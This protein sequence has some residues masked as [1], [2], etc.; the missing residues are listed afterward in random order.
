M[1][2]LPCRALPPTPPLQLPRIA[3]SPA[4]PLSGQYVSRK[5]MAEQHATWSDF[6]QPGSRFYCS[7]HLDRYTCRRSFPS[8][9]YKGRTAPKFIKSKVFHSIRE[10]CRKLT[11]HQFFLHM[12]VHV[13]CNPCAVHGSTC[14][15]C[16]YRTPGKSLYMIAR[17]F[18]LL[19]LN[20]SAWPSLAVA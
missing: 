9:Y 1:D 7:I 15:T 3:R 16:V 20:C 8:G 4:F 14:G 11:E 17:I 19:L 2:Y 12:C 10:I 6:F 18:F 13:T 5:D